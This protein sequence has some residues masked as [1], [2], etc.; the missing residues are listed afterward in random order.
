MIENIKNSE[1]ISKNDEATIKEFLESFDLRVEKIDS[2]KNINKTP[3]FGVESSDGFYFYC[4]VKSIDSDMNEAILHNTKLN[5]L[6][7]KIINSYEKF[8]SVNKNHFA[9]NVLCFLSNDFRIN[10]NSLEEYF[11]GYIDI[12]TEKLDTRKHRDGNAFDAVRNID[13]F[14]WFAD[15]NNVRY[16]INRIE[17]RF[18]NK[19]IS[20]FKIDSITENLKL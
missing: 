19:F 15:I 4:E 17:N 6:E 13:L 1:I 8:V 20:L 16:F 12:A 14:I 7:R 2:K 9:P 5:K 18:V 10:S 11:R 3:D